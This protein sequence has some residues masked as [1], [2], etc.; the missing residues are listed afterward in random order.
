MTSPSE[1]ATDHQMAAEDEEG[2][3]GR[4]PEPAGPLPTENPWQAD[5]ARVWQAGP[6]GV[7]PAEEP[8]VVG[9][10]DAEGSTAFTVPDAELEPV[11]EAPAPSATVSPVEEPEVVGQGDAESSAAF[12]VPDAEPEPVPEAPVASASASLSTRWQE[13]QAMFID[14]PRTSAELAAGL[15]D[16]S[17]QALV[18]FVK[19]QQDSLLAAWHGEDAGTEE[20]RTAVRHSRAFANRLADFSRET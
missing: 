6:V 11:P 8:E 4:I 13:I 15:V 20:L 9:R 10:G 2:M 5:Y 12:T 14:D 19:E 3:L 7:S 1:T 17:V 18:A 16:E